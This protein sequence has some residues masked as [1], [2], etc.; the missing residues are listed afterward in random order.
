MNYADIQEALINKGT[1]TLLEMAILA[2][3]GL[4]EVEEALWALV[5]E[6]SAIANDDGTFSAVILNSELGLLGLLVPSEAVARELSERA[7]ALLI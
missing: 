1:T 6:G 3:L 2:D 4:D 5:K 7:R